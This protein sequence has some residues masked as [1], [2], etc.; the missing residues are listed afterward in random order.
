MKKIKQVKKYSISYNDDKPI[1]YGISQN[2]DTKSCMLILHEESLDYC[3]KCNKMYTNTVYKWCKICQIN[4]LRN[5]LTQRNSGNEK[6]DNFI[7]EMQLKINH[8]N[9]RVFEWIPY[10]KFNNIK[11]I[12][13]GST[14][15]YSA[16]WKDGPL[17][18]DWNKKL[19]TRNSNKS[20]ILKYLC[21]SLN[22]TNYFLNEQ[23]GKY[24]INKKSN[25]I[26][27]YGISQNPITNN[28]IVVLDYAEGGNFN[29][30]MN[31]NYKNFYWIRKLNILLNIING[32]RE[33]HQK[34]MVYRNLHTGN[35][36][37]LRNNISDFGNEISIF[38]ELCREVGNKDDMNEIKIYGVM[39]YVAPEVLRGKPY[40]QA[41]D[42]Y[43]FGMIMYF[44]ATGKQPFVN[45]AH[46]ISLA[47]DMLFR[48]NPD[49]RPNVVKIEELIR[50][51][52]NSCNSML[53][54]HNHF[55]EAEDYRKL[56]LISFEK[57]KQTTHPQAIY[58]SRLLNSFTNKIPQYDKTY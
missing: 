4:Y 32:L 44:V 27:I 50:S 36:L 17:H 16:K 34:Q 30:W 10:D 41:A 6:I 45:R 26:N 42:I 37:F 49:S 7:Q 57:D 52:Y 1:I 31:K 20:V 19:Y 53:G 55:K 25:I 43:S 33:I 40:S 46:D 18:Y 2:P 58:T 8:L 3:V 29:N 11:K 22:L 48:L 54:L 38:I 47:L 56:H 51:F 35:V 9:D 39:P 15:V 5:N 13:K 28:Y 12:D 21:N 23:V 24:S 14:T